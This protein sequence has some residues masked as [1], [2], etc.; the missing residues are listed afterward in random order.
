MNTT[1][2]SFEYHN[3]L[4]EV[5]RQSD[6]RNY[7]LATTK[8]FSQGSLPKYPYRNYFY[9]IGLTYDGERTIKIGIE[10]FKVHKNSLMMIGP[11][12]IRQWLDNHHDVDTIAL[13]FN[14]DLFQSPMQGHFLSELAIF[15]PCIRHVIDLSEK[16]FD[17]IK[18]IFELLLQYKNQ[19][20]IVA[21]TAH[22]L[23]EI[24]TYLQSKHHQNTTQNTRRQSITNEFD[25]L[26][27]KHYLEQH[28][29]AFYADAMSLTANHLS[30]TIKSVTGQSAKK[31]IEA[32][33]LLEAKSLLKQTNM[34]MK[35]ITYW[36]G[37]EDPSYFTKVFKAAE[38]ITPLSYRNNSI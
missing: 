25:A 4:R 34:T 18:G 27:L 33:L 22:S 20:K 7:F 14:P 11:S 10:D 38:S 6:T 24:A 15:K 12:I 2:K 13:F 21:A 30:E 37:F 32:I 1:L 28:D 9:G 19:E 5:L 29:V 16:D 31:R 3:F 17:A 8:D 26:L 36:L 35:E 23:I